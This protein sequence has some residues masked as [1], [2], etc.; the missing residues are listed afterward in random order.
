[1]PIPVT[2]PVLGLP[3]NPILSLPSAAQQR[4][5]IET[6]LARR[7]V[8]RGVPVEEVYRFKAHL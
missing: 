7:H 5:P 2:V 1:M 3:A 6:L 4:A 8:Q